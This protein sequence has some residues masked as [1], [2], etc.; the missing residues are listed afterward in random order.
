MDGGGQV[1]DSAGGKTAGLRGSNAS[2]GQKFVANL[3]KHL[4]T[5]STGKKYRSRVM[6]PAVQKH[7]PLLVPAIEQSITNT[8]KVIEDKIN[9]TGSA[10]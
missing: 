10:G 6:Y 3:D 4:P 5:K 1:Y 9:G 7:L 8:C 2:A